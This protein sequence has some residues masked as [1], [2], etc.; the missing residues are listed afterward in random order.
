WVNPLELPSGDKYSVKFTRMVSNLPLQG[1][2]GFTGRIWYEGMRQ[3]MP[4]GIALSTAIGTL[5]RHL[6]IS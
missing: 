6:P 5:I 4:C 3:M 1:F 2:L